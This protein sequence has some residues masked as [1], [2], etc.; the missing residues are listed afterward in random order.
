MKYILI[1]LVVLYVLYRK[2]KNNF[3]KQ[4][5]DTLAVKRQLLIKVLEDRGIDLETDKVWLQTFDAFRDFPSIYHFDG[6]TFLADNDTINGYSAP[7]GN[8]DKRYLDALHKGLISYI[9]ETTKADWFYGVEQRKVGIPWL[10]AW[11]RAFGV[12]V[13][14]PI[15]IVKIAFEGKLKRI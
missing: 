15:I 6:E 4:D 7:G 14:K 3:F 10:T 8:H 2:S 5:R 12:F 9:V 13:L 1:I 11:S